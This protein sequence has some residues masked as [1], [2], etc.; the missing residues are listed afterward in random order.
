[1]GGGRQKN[2]CSGPRISKIWMMSLTLW[3][4]LGKQEWEKWRVTPR[5]SLWLP[6]GLLACDTMPHTIKRSLF[7]TT[8]YNCEYSIFDFKKVHYCVF[9]C[10]FFAFYFLH[11]IGIRCDKH[12]QSC[13]PIE[14]L[15]HNDFDAIE[16][17]SSKHVM[18]ASRERETR[19]RASSRSWIVLY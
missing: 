19:D 1:M 13:S 18:I 9:K 11:S 10:S 8:A 17:G 4:P 12:Y 2:F 5:T 16:Y 14:N 3:T 15:F 7:L 6:F